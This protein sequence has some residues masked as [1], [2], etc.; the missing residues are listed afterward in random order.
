MDFSY[1][2]IV[3]ILIPFLFYFIIKAFFE[4]YKKFNCNENIT[5]FDIAR[6]IL[7]SND[8]KDT[9]IVEIKTGD[10]TDHYDYKQGVVRLSSNV[11]YGTSLYSVAMAIYCAN[12]A[13]R[14]KKNNCLKNIGL[15][16]GL[17][18]YLYGLIGILLLL[19]VFTMDNSVL[20]VIILLFISIYL[21]ELVIMPFKLKNIEILVNVANDNEFIEKEFD[22]DFVNLQR[23][24]I[25]SSLAKAVVLLNKV[26]V[27]LIDY[28]KKS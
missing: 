8:M 11:Y 27:N 16:D 13:V 21:Y 18:E 5:G 10:L 1:I 24:I 7:D 26:L 28:I 9:Y 20:L 19:W 23:V 2:F 22:N 6:K 12:I 3:V 25:L 17:I 15:I 4:K 14:S